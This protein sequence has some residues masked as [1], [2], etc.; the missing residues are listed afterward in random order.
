MSLFREKLGVFGNNEGNFIKIY[1]FIVFIENNDVTNK[2]D[3]DW[4]VED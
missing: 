2:E 4:S 1:F 3:N